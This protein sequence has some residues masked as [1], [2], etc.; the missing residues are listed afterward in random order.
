MRKAL[1]M[2]A[3]ISNVVLRDRWIDHARG[4]FWS[5]SAPPRPVPCFPWS[6]RPRRFADRMNLGITYRVTSFSRQTIDGIREMLIDQI[7]NPT[8][9]ATKRGRRESAVRAA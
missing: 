6:F 8:D 3:G 5:I 4:R 7:E 2:T 9:A 1:P